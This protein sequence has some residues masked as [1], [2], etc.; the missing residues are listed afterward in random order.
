M[1]KALKS[2]FNLLFSI[3]NAKDGLQTC[4]NIMVLIRFLCGCRLLFR[5]QISSW[6]LQNP[7]RTFST[8]LAL[9][10][11]P[12][13]ESAEDEQG[14][15]SLC[16]RHGQPYP[17]VVQAHWKEDEAGNQQQ[18]SAQQDK[19]QGFANPFDTLIIAD[20]GDIQDEKH[21]SCGKIRE[22]VDSNPARLAVCVDKQHHQQVG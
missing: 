8:L 17:L 3:E 11:R 1:I 21:D 22:S 13:H 16:Y 19:H 20:D 12:R 2:G 10:P 9:Q 5:H 18:K 15:G 4:E 7:P 14:G 6:L